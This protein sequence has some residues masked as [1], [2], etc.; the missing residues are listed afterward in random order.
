LLVS[1]YGLDLDGW[2]LAEAK[3]VSLFGRIIAGWGEHEG[4]EQAWLARLS[5]ACPADLDGDGFVGMTDVLELLA[6]MGPC[7]S[8]EAC[9]ADVNGD[10]VVNITDFT[11]M[12]AA[13]GPCP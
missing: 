12:L 7:G 10:C 5:P 2:R 8:C 9:L 6:T 4:E 11:A 3:A 13:W 1:D